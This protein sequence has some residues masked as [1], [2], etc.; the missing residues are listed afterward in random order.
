MKKI[1]SLLTAALMSTV[2]FAVEPQVK[3]FDFGN[4]TAN[5]WGVP[6]SA[7]DGKTAADTVSY[8]YQ[9][10]Q[11][12]LIDTQT[13][14]QILCDTGLLIGAQ[15][16]GIVLPVMDFPVGKIVVNY[17]A[18]MD[19]NTEVAVTSLEKTSG[20]GIVIKPAPAAVIPGGLV[21]GIPYTEYATAKLKGPGADNTQTFSIKPEYTA[22]GTQYVLRVTTANKYMLVHSVALYEAQGVESV[23]LDNHKDTI[24]VGEKL[25]LAA[26]ILP[27]DAM[28]KSAVWSTSDNN[29]AS[30]STDGKVSAKAVGDVEIIYTVTTLTDQ[31]IADTCRLHINPAGEV[32]DDFTVVY[33]F[34]SNDCWGLPTTATDA[35]DEFECESAGAS[36]SIAGAAGTGM[37]LAKSQYQYVNNSLKLAPKNTSGTYIQFQQFPFA[38]GKIVVELDPALT[39]TNPA[40]LNVTDAGVTQTVLGKTSTV[41]T[42]YTQFD[43][44]VSVTKDVDSVMTYNIKPDYRAAFTDYY[45][46]CSN[47]GRTVN[48]KRITVYKHIAAT[49]AA[50]AQDVYKVSPNKTLALDLDLTP[51]NTTAM[52]TFTSLNPEIAT[53]DVNGVVTAGGAFGT[54]K[55]VMDAD[56]L[57]DTCDLEVCIAPK[58]V[59]DFTSND[60]WGFPTELT[61]GEAEYTCN[62]QTVVVN[63]AS[64]L[65]AGQGGY[66]FDASTNSLISWV[67]LTPKSNVGFVKLPQ[68]DFPVGKFVVNMTESVT[69]KCRFTDVGKKI[70]TMYGW[71][72]YTDTVAGSGAYY[73][74]EAGRAVGLDY[75][76]RPTSTGKLYIKSI[77]VYEYVAPETIA[78]NQKNLELE[79][80]ETAN[81]S[82][83][84][85]PIDATYKAVT[86]T[87]LDT[88]V[89]KVDATG[90][91]TAVG[92]GSTSIIATVGALS[93]TCNVTVIVPADRRIY[94]Y[95]LRMTEVDEVCTFAFKTNI[96]PT[97]ASVVFYRND[98]VIARKVVTVGNDKAYSIAVAKEEIPGKPGEK[99][100]WGVEVKSTK[101]ENMAEVLKSVVGDKYNFY[102]MQGWA[103]NNCTESE[104]FGNS[105]LTVI[106]GLS[107]GGSARTKNQPGGIYS[108]NAAMESLD[109]TDN[110]GFAQA[111]LP[112]PNNASERQDFKR[113]CVDPKDGMI[114]FNSTTAIYK[115]NP[116]DTAHY[117]NILEGK[118][119]ITKVNC[120]YAW[121]GVVYFLDNANTSTGATLKK[122]DAEG[123]ITTIAQNTTW[124]VQDMS[125]TT[126]GR[127]GLWLAQ[128]RWNLDAFSVLTHVSAAG[129]V[130]YTVTSSSDADVKALFP[131]GNNASYRGQ[132]TYNVKE[133]LLAFGGNKTAAVYHVTYDAT[134]GVPALELV[135]RTGSI[136]S[137]IDG[138]AFDYAGNLYVASASTEQLYI[139]AM[140]IENNALTTPAAAAQAIEFAGLAT[141][142]D[143]VAGKTIRRVVND[144][145]GVYALALDAAGAPTLVKA[146]FEGN[147]LVQYATDF[148]KVTA[149]EA[150]TMV[151]SD[152]ALTAD[153]VL[154]GIN[155]EHATT[156]KTIGQQPV[157]Y[158][159]N[160]DGTGAIWINTDDLVGSNENF[161]AGN[162]ANAT[163]DKLAYSGT[164][165]DGEIVMRAMTQGSGNRSRFG[166]MKIKEG[167]V[168]DKTRNQ[169][170]EAFTATADIT[171]IAA[172]TKGN[173]IW[174]GADITPVEWT[175]VYSETSLAQGATPTVVGTMS[176]DYTGIKGFSV[177][178]KAD[179]DLMLIPAEDGAKVLD[180]TAGLDKATAYQTLST[181]APTGT[182]A[183][184]YAALVAD[185]A[186][187][188]LMRDASIVLLNLQD[189]PTTGWFD[190]IEIA[191]KA[192]KIIRDG[193]IYIIRDNVMYNMQGQIVR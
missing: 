117:T 135:Q 118:E 181:E 76:F 67:A 64:G 107:D 147:I 16:A 153:G 68:F 100:A 59:I 7:K 173:Y 95:D 48:I 78:L 162:F 116:A 73:T 9:G 85:T 38:V 81:L 157:I 110:N 97:E 136:G 150:G 180:I 83:T 137:N 171:L 74:S 66:N 175:P 80:A 88:L 163:V 60:C 113:I 126:D 19:A 99:L 131:Q 105:Y 142:A 160:A 184:M 10:S 51:V 114:Y 192:I 164:I 129:A 12:T 141:L 13:G 148:C 70:L 120:C 169:D 1:F 71:T 5:P 183:F 36:F 186:K 182:P 17:D 56:G 37:S 139:Y 151:L 185:G 75:Y 124:G 89:A 108:F 93:D 50:F 177:A 24:K 30:V 54:T 57:K 178:K 34:T 23:T 96:V 125:I 62:G 14:C 145:N 176:S 46:R 28:Y 187:V 21:I 174:S 121:D 149:V 65:M 191:P 79:A 146:D 2:M 104:Y 90:L 31:V 128:H 189:G 130:D 101:V 58:K 44:T 138:L 27:E 103:I 82:A 33:D 170:L 63:G 32:A 92:A 35:L 122:I 25:T 167:A 127:G 53:V 8:T 119:G 134:T 18:K 86:Y 188:M 49:K 106:H 144:N 133:D 77:E 172:P 72:S 69:A 193:Q 29:I 152:I 132:C 102:L 22:A 159:W 158:K 98:A 140:P 161:A 94:A 143:A 3:T 168:G 11:I 91:V 20:G 42:S 165:A 111:L 84:V 39:S 87:S 43:N 26:T 115:I 6:T 47:N 45:L 123:N 156:T 55:I 4:P 41:Y 15:Y 112:T 52:L 61:T 40:P 166:I 109:A 155:A 154:V 190:N 179:K